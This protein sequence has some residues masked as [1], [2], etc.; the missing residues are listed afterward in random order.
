MSMQDLTNKLHLITLKEALNEKLKE[1]IDE[2]IFI[3]DVGFKR[4]ILMWVI[5][6]PTY[7]IDLAY[8]FF[9]GVL[10]FKVQIKFKKFNYCIPNNFH[11]S[12]QD[13]KDFGIVTRFSASTV[14][15]CLITAN[16]ELKK[17]INGL[18]ALQRKIRQNG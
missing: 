2:H 3:D 6:K 1:K 14:E 10:T 18:S 15:S 17:A 5:T 4:V 11:F 9:N 8:E 7:I 16:K 13:I 12:I